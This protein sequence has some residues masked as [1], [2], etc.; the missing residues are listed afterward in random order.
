MKRVIIA[1]ALGT[2]LPEPASASATASVAP[3]TLP[4][5][6]TGR[7]TIGYQPI[8]CI[9]APCPPGRDSVRMPDRVIAYVD[10]IELEPGSAADDRWSRF[11]LQARHAEVAVEGRVS[12]RQSPVGNKTTA[13]VA[14]ASSAE[15]IWKP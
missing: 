2:L 8:Y 3:I 13:F 7:F 11:A 10:A 9:R 5:A 14:V 4:P 6:F 1:L 15:G 12:F